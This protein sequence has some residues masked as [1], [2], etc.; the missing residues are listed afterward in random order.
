[1]C[2]WKPTSPRS[3]AIKQKK[4]NPQENEFP[5]RFLQINVPSQLSNSKYEVIK[6]LWFCDFDDNIE[7]VNDFNISKESLV[8]IQQMY[9]CA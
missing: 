2:L 6:I 9:V 3:K 1:M 5:H 4:I 8:H 7:S